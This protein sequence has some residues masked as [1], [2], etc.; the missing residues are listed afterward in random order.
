MA[1]DQCR[2]RTSDRMV[3]PHASDSAQYAA[4]VEAVRGAG[5][6]LGGATNDYDALLGAIGNA[7]IVLLGE[8][9]H[10][11]HEFYK[12]RADITRRLIV[13]RGFRAVIAEADWPDAHRV[14]NY[15]RGKS[16]DADANG[17]LSGFK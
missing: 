13:E 7:R 17:A 9:S 15:V 16:A 5:H 8:A 11:T 6:R 10:G 12:A 14:S 1:E 4:A 3:L 2:K